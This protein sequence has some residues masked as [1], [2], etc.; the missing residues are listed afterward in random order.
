MQSETKPRTSIIKF[1]EAELSPCTEV[2]REITKKH[3]AKIHEICSETSLAL[4]ELR[5]GVE[6]M[7]YDTMEMLNLDAR[8][9][10][11]VLDERPSVVRELMDRETDELTTERLIQMLE[12]LRPL[13]Q[14]S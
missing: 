8:T 12:T 14:N 4:Q 10:V 13:Q 11:E 3:D 6:Y 2:D 1:P 5:H 9:L 7:L